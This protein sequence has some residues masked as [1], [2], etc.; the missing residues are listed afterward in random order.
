VDVGSVDF[1]GVGA[2]LTEGAIGPTLVRLA[3]PTAVGIA[4][5][6]L[7]QLVDTFYVGMLGSSALA[8]MG[9]ALPVTLFVM[10]VALGI[11]V[12]ATALISRA[13]GEGDRTQVRRLTTDSLVLA[14][15]VVVVVALAGIL[16]L[17]GLFALLGAPPDIV[18]L[19][20]SYMVPWYLGVGLLVIP[21]VGNSA[22]R[23]T[24]D[25]KTPMVIMV[26]AGV[27]NAILDPVLIFGLG[28]FPRLELTGA[29]LA[30]VISWA[31][32][33]VTTLWVLIRREKMVSFRIP[34]ARDVLGSWRA[35]LHVGGPSTLTQLMQPLG[36]GA[37]IRLVAESGPDA[38]AGYAVGARVDTLALVGIFALSAVS[39]PFV[40][41]NLGAGRM[42]RIAAGLRFLALACIGWGAAMLLLLFGLADP[43]AH[44]FSD[45]TSVLEASTT[46]LQVL[47]WSYGLLGIATV[48]GSV[49]NPLGRPFLSTGL[50][51]LRFGL[52]LTGAFIG[53]SLAGLT[54]IFVGL[55]TGFSVSGIIAWIVI[56]PLASARGPG[57]S[58]LIPTSL[59][60]ETSAE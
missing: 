11:G 20:A 45:E 4:A 5:L 58:A 25:M 33:F 42:D 56:A 24:G 60:P 1:E 15:L 31:A 40:G 51:G 32:A 38:V 28:P 9:F 17:G 52:G 12:G 13:I 44:A 39:S 14:N 55:A 47:P 34:R 41:Q 37:L 2:R 6:M 8:A 19:I 26:V 10:H 3:V 21:M 50:A 46:Y 53:M 43:I 16:T 27:A 7:F 59:R 48:V 49:L 35:V 57:S 29:A 30:T 54:G 18:E 23:A 22:I 36:A